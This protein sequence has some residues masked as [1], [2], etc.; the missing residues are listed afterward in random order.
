MKKIYIYLL[1]FVSFVSCDD[2]LDT[3]DY[4]NK[5]DQNFPLTEKD[6]LLALASCYHV[7]ATCQEHSSYFHGDVTSDDRLGGGGP[8]DRIQHACDKLLKFDEIMYDDNWK[9]HYTGIYR[10]NKL[11]EAINKIKFS[12]ETAKNT[13]LGETYFMRAY[14][15]FELTKMFGDIPLLVN[16][17]PV[18][19]PRTPASEVFAQIAFDLKA[20]IGL[21][22]A[23]DYN[24]Q[25]KRNLGHATKWAAEGL[26]ARA[27]LFY[28]GY[29]QQSEMPIAGGGM[30]SKKEVITY[31]EDC[32]ANSGHQLVDDFRNMW[33]YTNSL[34]GDDY[35]YNQGRNLSWVGDDNNVETIFAI[36]FGTKGDWSNIDYANMVALGWSF[37]GQT[38]YANVFPF[39]QGWG[40]GT[41]NPKFVEDWIRIEPN[42]TIRRNGSIIDLRSPEEGLVSYEEG[43]W[44]QMN[45]GGF[46]QKKYI[47]INAWVDKD[48]K[49]FKSYST[50]MFG[51][52]DDYS[53]AN[54]QDQVLLRFA[55]VLLMHSELTETVDG[56]NRV[57]A[58]VKLPPLSAYTLEKLQ[59]ERRF[60]LAFEGGRYYDL[61]RWYGKNAGVVIDKNQNGAKVLNNR[62]ESVI[63][64]NLTKRIQETGGFYQIPHTEI[65]LSEGVLTQNPGWTGSDINL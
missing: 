55:D 64:Y 48:A 12:T 18:N 33:P 24:S 35:V 19:I 1:L 11:L 42:D 38:N 62:V 53:F 61:L 41:V 50:L 54:T 47:A 37:R 20:A 22:P 56:I 27:F 26:L 59:C 30:L 14:F 31:L 52:L 15:Y 63:N 29:Y 13:I 2:F 23:V 9:R 46:W 7:M 10:A 49:T 45:D 5:N 51:G 8:N 16:S 43:G 32:I 65:E 25:P 36:K 58:R 21:L 3:V 6:A 34:T 60:E 57:R 39:G 44:E 4:T 17:E 40:L 28:I